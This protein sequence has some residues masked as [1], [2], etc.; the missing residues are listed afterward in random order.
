MIFSFGRPS[1]NEVVEVH[2]FPSDMAERVKEA[3][4]LLARGQVR[5]PS[6]SGISV[7]IAGQS[8]N[9]P[10]RVYYDNQLLLS[11]INGSDDIALISLCLGTRHWDGFLRE[12]CLRRLLRSDENWTAAFV[13]QLLGEYVLEIIQPIQERFTAG[14]EAKYLGFVVENVKNLDYLERRAIS[15]W[16]VYYRARFP[17]YNDYPAVKALT[18]LRAA[19]RA[20]AK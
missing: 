12:Q 10:Y 15:Y 20:E 8:L 5:A 16:N 2:A 11:S 6:E 3:V 7:C 13:I 1:G 17:K 19:A 4:Q 14:I 9:I 18:T